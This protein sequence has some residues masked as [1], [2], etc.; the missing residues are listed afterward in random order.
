[1]RNAIVNKEYNIINSNNYRLIKYTNKVYLV[2]LNTADLPSYKFKFSLFFLQLIVNLLN[3][4]QIG[5]SLRTVITCITYIM[6]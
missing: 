1:M 3:A 6:L 2:V 5:F 4:Y